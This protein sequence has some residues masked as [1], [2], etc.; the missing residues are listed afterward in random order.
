[1]SSNP[2]DLETEVKRLRAQVAALRRLLDVTSWLND[3]LLSPDPEPERLLSTIMDTAA[4]LTGCESAAVLLWDENRNELYFAATNSNNPNAPNLIGTAVPME[5]I[6]GT[7]FTTRLPQRVDNTMVDD[8]HYKGVDK[9]VKFVT[10]SLMGVPMIARAQTIGVLEVVNKQRPPF[11]PRDEQVLLLLAQEAAVAIQVARLLMALNTANRELS[12]VDR[13][14]DTFISIASHELRTPLGIILGYA[15]F[16]MEDAPTPEAAEYADTVMKSALH[17]RSILD[18]MATLR[19][20]TTAIKDLAP[21]PIKLETLKSDLEAEIGSI[22]GASGHHITIHDMPIDTTVIADRARLELA[23]ANVLDNAVRFTPPPGTIEIGATVHGSSEVWITITDTGVGIEHENLERI[24]DEFFQVED[25]MTRTH[26][27]LGIGLSV[28]RSLIKLF[29][30]RIWAESG[31][32][33]RGTTIT[34][35]LPRAEDT[36]EAQANPPNS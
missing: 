1:M 22:P 20:L 29:G 31:G 14:K 36:V 33:R 16:L 25:H 24:F 13:L 3:S 26:G 5:S 18:S 2:N 15:T 17:L 34:I 10:R 23:F 21:E 19:Y 4:N 8:R 28:A 32:L 30:G 35:A 7:I 11:L 6:A 12:E 9:D 27:G